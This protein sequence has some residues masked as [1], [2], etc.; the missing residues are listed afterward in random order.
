MVAGDTRQSGSVGSLGSRLRVFGRVL[1]G[2]RAWG[3]G[4]PDVGGLCTPC[5]STADKALADVLS[6]SACPRFFV[7]QRWCPL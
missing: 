3:E 6:S 4:C 7:A 1:E 2:A 5:P